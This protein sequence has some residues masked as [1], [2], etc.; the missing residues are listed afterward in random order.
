[1]FELLSGGS[2]QGDIGVEREASLEPK[3]G[4]PRANAL[5]MPHSNP[6][7]ACARNEPPT[8]MITRPTEL[9]EVNSDNV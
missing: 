2:G 6:E 4:R 9:A 7:L 1:V 3:R 5:R 8:D